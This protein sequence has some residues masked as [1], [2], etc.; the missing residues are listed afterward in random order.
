MTSEIHLVP[1]IL[2]FYGFVHLFIQNVFTEDYYQVSFP[3]GSML[4]NV[5]AN[6]GHM[7][8]IPDLGRF[9]ML[10]SNQAHMPQLLK[11]EWSR[12]WAPQE[13]PPVRIL[14][15]ATKSSLCFFATREKPTQQQTI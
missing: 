12:A 10:Q 8:S 6:A 13:K 11:P 9:H 15:A 7:G 1:N 4:K 2:Q 5:P 14:P 3:S